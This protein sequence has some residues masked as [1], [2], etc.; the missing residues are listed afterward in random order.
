MNTSED[1]SVANLALVAPDLDDAINELGPED[2]TA[3][4]LRFFEQKEFRT[5]GE[6]MGNNEDAARMRVN[7]ALDKLHKMLKQ[8]GV[9]LSAAAL[10]TALAAE[11]VT[12]V[13]VGM[14]VSV[15]TAAL[16]GT[17]TGGTTFTFINIMSMIKVKIAIAS[18]IAVAA[19]AVPIVQHGTIQALRRENEGLK[20]QVA[21]IATLQQQLAGA[22][23]DAA[24]TVGATLPEAKVRELARLRNEVAH[25]RA[26]TNELAKAR[27]QI[28]TLNQHAIAGAAPDVG[29]T[30]VSPSGVFPG[31]ENHITNQ[32]TNI[33]LNNLRL[34]EEAKQKWASENHKQNGDIPT[35]EDL[36]P[37]FGQGPDGARP[38]GIQG[39]LPNEVVVEKLAHCPGGGVYKLGAVGEKP[40]C[41]IPGYVLP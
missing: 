12:V 17:A 38:N 8:R 31:N 9:V 14:A 19:L 29:M 10:G 16:S 39:V 4:L 25:L 36:R 7:R 11:A 2:R 34:I 15:A 24:K 13:P 5:M 27:Q 18:A 30:I 28:Q 22:L 6:L 33:C 21:Q 3:I 37:Y 20:Q 26:Q 32:I 35:M 41:S 40:T 1:H 23:Q